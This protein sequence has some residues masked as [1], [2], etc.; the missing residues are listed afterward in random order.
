MAVDAVLP[1]GAIEAKYPSGSIGLG[2]RQQCGHAMHDIGRDFS[3][4]DELLAE[5]AMQARP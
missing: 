1:P 2:T 3:A 5:A 4:V